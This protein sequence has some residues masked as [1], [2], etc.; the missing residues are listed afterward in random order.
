MNDHEG[1]RVTS[2][3]CPSD[4]IET[5]VEKKQDNKSGTGKSRKGSKFEKV[6]WIWE[7]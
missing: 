2:Q 5:D 1:S 7:S 6:W 3:R 4:S